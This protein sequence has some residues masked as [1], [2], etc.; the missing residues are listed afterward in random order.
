MY[1]PLLE[2]AKVAK[3]IG[4][5]KF[6]TTKEQLVAIQKQE[7]SSYKKIPVVSQTPGAATVVFTYGKD[8]KISLAVKPAK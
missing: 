8:V 3:A 7:D 1:N 2:G 4:I 5:S 6:D